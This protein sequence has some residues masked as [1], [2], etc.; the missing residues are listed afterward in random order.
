MFGIFS[1]RNIVICIRFC[2]KVI[3][4]WLNQC[5]DSVVFMDD[6]RLYIRAC[7]QWRLLV[8]MRKMS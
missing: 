4:N 3:Y 1:G 7:G 2:L 8:K 5:D 6:I